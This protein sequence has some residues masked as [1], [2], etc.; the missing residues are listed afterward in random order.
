MI[1]FLFGKDIYNLQEKLKEI[2]KEEKEKNKN[3]LSCDKID[4]ETSDFEDFWNKFINVSMFARKKLFFIENVFFSE[5]FKKKFIENIAK[6]A[7]SQDTLI[8]YEKKEIKKS[9]N[10]FVLLKKKAK[11]QEFDIP[12]G[13]S[14]NSW[15]KKEFEELGFQ[16]RN[17][18]VSRLLEFRG[19]DTWALANEVKKLVSFKLKDGKK[20]EV[21]D[22]ELLVKPKIETAIFE[23]I[24]AMGRRDKKKFLKL[25]QN[26]LEKGEEPVYLLNMINFQARTLLLARVFRDK[27]KNLADFLKLGVFHPFVAK[28]AWTASY[29]FSFEQLK[30]IYQKIFEADLA[31][32]TGKQGPKEALM[33]LGT[34]I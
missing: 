2:E 7:E 22:V 3:S 20:I 6:M 25:L 8:I 31:I 24:D 13:A 15:L 33:A 18:A 30:K 10:F 4:A 29:N 21:N 17:E 28:K 19:S 26:H 32:K 11:I 27:R 12:K 5:D 1:L 9:D 23:T 16:A 34:E 14:L